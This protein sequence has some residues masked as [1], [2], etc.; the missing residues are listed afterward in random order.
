[1]KIAIVY[2]HESENVINLFGIPNREKIGQKTIKRITNALRKRHHKVATF[3]G[4]KNLIPHLEK[5]M[6]QVLK[7]ERPGMVFNLS[8]G[9]QG[10]ARYT[11]IPSILEMVGIPYVGSGPLAHSLALDKVVTKMLLKQH[12]LPTP[13]F[14][15]IKTPGE[16]P[17]DPAYPLIVKPKNEAVS[18]GI[19]IVNN[20]QELLEASEL[21]FTTFHQAVL[22]ER[23]IEGRE[24]NVGLLGN[25]PLQV[26][27]PAEILFDKSGPPIYTYED[28]TRSSNREIKVQCPASL[29]EELRKTAED[30]AVRAFSSLGCFDCARVDMRLDKENQFHIL[31]INSL[32]SIGEHGSYTH[33]AAAAGLDYDALVNKL[34]D[35]ASARYF[36]TPN[37]PQQEKKEAVQPENRVFFFLT[38]QR[39]NIEK[40]VKDW[41]NRYN[42]SVDDP[43]VKETIDEIS[44]R[45]KA[46]GLL[47][48]PALSDNRST[49]TFETEEGLSGGTLLVINTAFP[50]HREFPSQTFRREPELLYGTGIGSFGAPIAM[51]EYVLRALRSI[52][53]LRRTKLGILLCTDENN[54][55]KQSN[56]FITRAAETAEQVL[57]ICTGT[58]DGRVYIQRRGQR[59]YHFSAAEKPQRPGQTKRKPKM[60]SWFCTKV[61][62]LIGLTDQKKRICIYPTSIRTSS[63]PM[64][65]PH[66]AEATL[67]VS[68]LQH[69]AITDLED[70]MQSMI[71]QDG[72]QG[73]LHR[74]SDIPPMNNKKRNMTLYKMIEA[75]AEKWE[76]PCAHESSATPSP[77]GFIP[78]TIPVLCG[79]GPAA[80]DL[81]TPNEGVYRISVIQ[82]TLL[83][84][85]FLLAGARS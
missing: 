46:M 5:F 22:V 75:V 85:L 34:V 10:Q 18:F 12:N 81:H 73:V 71:K 80:K 33:A 53:R 41:V 40:C 79:I 1:M 69:T 35:V 82:R 83:V 50:A 25:N 17:H 20:D 66:K 2:N 37:L 62:S 28:K 43:S 58:Y 51:V 72:Y 60:L 57:F 59:K 42:T 44:K 13:E 52:K 45:Y 21:I 56:A 29:P 39:D 65:V 7:G 36:G 8:Y 54:D 63:Y 16:M 15:V 9:I 77:A 32:P 26:L 49:W 47:P 31:E 38:K 19:R 64:E 27:P 14:A 3:E 76:I 68:Y 4:D 61:N 48:L 74:I 70:I 6:P 23:Y 24:I 30:L 84:T 67:L 78:D 11:H 55:Y